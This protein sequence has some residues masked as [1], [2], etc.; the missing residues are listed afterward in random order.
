MKIYAA[1]RKGITLT[2]IAGKDIWLKCYHDL[3]EI[4]EY[5]KI[6][7]VYSQPSYPAGSSLDKCVYASVPAFCIDYHTLEMGNLEDFL[8]DIEHLH[9]DDLT[10]FTVCQPVN[11]LTTAELKNELYKCP[12]RQF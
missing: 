9:R 1:N 12:P 8:E 3:Y 10:H 2:D 5:V 7:E 4:D 11:M 6:F